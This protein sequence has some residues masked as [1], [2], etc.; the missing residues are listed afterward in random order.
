M[1][2]LKKIINS[3]KLDN[4]E[5]L[6]DSG[7]IDVKFLHETIPFEVYSVKTLNHELRCADNH[8]LFDENLNEVF[9]RNLKIGDHIITENGV[10]EII[11]IKNTGQYETMYD[12]E[13]SENSNHRYYT[14]GILS[15]NTHLIKTIAKFLG[16]PCNISDC[17]KFSATGY[18]GDDVENCLVGLLRECNYN[19]PLAE[20]GIVI[21]DEIDKL[22]TKSEN[23][24]ITRDVSGECVQQGL[25]KIIEGGKIAVPP[26]GGR[27]HPNQECIEIDT[28][29]ILFIG[30]G[31]FAGLDKIIEKNH[32]KKHV[33]F[34]TNNDINKNH[35]EENYFKLVETDDL[36]KFGLIPEFLGRFPIITCTNDLKREDLIKILTEPKNSIIKQYQKLLKY[37]NVNLIFTQEALNQIADMTLENKTGA[38]GLRKII[39]R[40]LTDVMFEYAGSKRNKK[41]II[42]K[43]FVDNIFNIKEPLTNKKT[44]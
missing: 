10:E 12:F 27:K 42:D 18:T 15:H 11:T 22:A 21:L 7:F 1:Q 25:L 26:N 3:Y 41:I 33:G 28:T 39:E 17:T 20:M 31:A 16:V 35:E 5:I 34:N 8:I 4:Y 9:V 24:S 32:N 30:L 37:D 13:L 40:I 23:P 43:V 29:N 38:R 2:D 14:N 6:T 36:R 44:A 19:I